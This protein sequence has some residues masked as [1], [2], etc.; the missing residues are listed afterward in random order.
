MSRKSNNLVVLNGKFRLVM[1]DQI[2]DGEIS[3]PVVTFKVC[4]DG[5]ENGGH[6]H[7]LAYDR[8]AEE[9]IATTRAY[10]ELTE[11][12]RVIPDPI[13]GGSMDVFVQGWLRSTDKSAYIIAESVCFHTYQVVREYAIQLMNQRRQK[14]GLAE[15]APS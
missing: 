11:S 5:E 1:L 10:T 4:T 12:G 7:V 3:R 13:A 8:M 6:H 2:E 15:S 14:P 9:I